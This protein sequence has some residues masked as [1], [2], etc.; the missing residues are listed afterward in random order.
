MNSFLDLLNAVVSGSPVSESLQTQSERRFTWSL[1][2]TSFWTVPGSKKQ[3]KLGMKLCFSSCTALNS[4]KEP[5]SEPSN[6]TYTHN[7]LQNQPHLS[8]FGW[9]ISFLHTIV[10]FA[11][12]GCSHLKHHLTHTCR[13]KPH[14]RTSSSRKPLQGEEELLLGKATG[15]KNRICVGLDLRVQFQ[16]PL[17]SDSFRVHWTL[18]W[19]AHSR[20][21]PL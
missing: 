5:L 11:V 20:H 6:K 13:K 14:Q 4:N 9:N 17:V 1:H 21:R 2:C 18:K 7:P 10:M 3:N 15:K 19:K 16:V 8:I 12:G